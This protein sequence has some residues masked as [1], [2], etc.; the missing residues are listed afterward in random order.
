MQGEIKAFEGFIGRERQH[1][2]ACTMC[3]EKAQ[4]TDV[5]VGGVEGSRTCCCTSLDLL[6]A[7]ALFLL[8]KSA[9]VNFEGWRGAGC[10]ELG[11]IFPGSIRDNLLKY[12]NRMQG[13]EG[14]NH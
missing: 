13:S 4:L 8:R 3:S 10:C 9:G 7:G 5:A 1:Y 6:A 11:F 2:P 12:S 14:E